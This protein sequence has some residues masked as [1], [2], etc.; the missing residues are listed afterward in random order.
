[1]R[2]NTV[3]KCVFMMWIYGNHDRF[4]PFLQMTT[5]TC[6]APL[7][8][9]LSWTLFKTLPVQESKLEEQVPKDLWNVSLKCVSCIL[10]QSHLLLQHLL[11]PLPT[12]QIPSLLPWFP[13]QTLVQTMMSTLQQGAAHLGLVG[14]HV[15]ATAGQM[16]AISGRITGPV[17][18]SFRVCFALGNMTTSLSF[19][20]GGFYPEVDFGSPDGSP[21][22]DPS[23]R[24]P[25]D[26]QA[27]RGFGAWHPPPQVSR[28]DGAPLAPRPG[29]PY[30]SEEEEVSWRPGPPF[31][32]FTDRSSGGAPRR[33]YESEA[34]P[35]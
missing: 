33:V 16:G 9:L 2:L 32:P 28:P 12:G 22:Q 34:P 24:I 14:V 6:A 4:S 19:S 17:V 30:Q 27:G 7:T 1:M 10:I 8:R 25:Q 5:P 20:I 35:C 13:G 11:T 31:P 18:S 23:L 3:L 26:P 15:T 21:I 29:R